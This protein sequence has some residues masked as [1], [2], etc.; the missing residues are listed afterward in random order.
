MN[1]PLCTLNGRGNQFI[2]LHR[3][4][5]PIRM[6]P[7]EA[8]MRAKSPIAVSAVRPAALVAC[9]SGNEARMRDGIQ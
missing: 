2:S 1:Y 5:E 3:T 4:G 7:R 6:V 8:F 9:A